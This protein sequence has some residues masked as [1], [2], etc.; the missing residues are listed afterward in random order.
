MCALGIVLGEAVTAPALCC[1]GALWLMCSNTGIES[2]FLQASVLWP[3]LAGTSLVE[4]RLAS[5]LP[6]PPEYWDYRYGLSHPV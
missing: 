4:I 2:T 1:S 3:W 6:S 5:D